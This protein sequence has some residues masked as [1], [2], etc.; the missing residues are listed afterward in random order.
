MSPS[1]ADREPS[2][3]VVGSAGVGD[4]SGLSR[5]DEHFGL[6]W[7]GGD[8]DSSN[9]QLKPGCQLGGVTIVRLLAEG[10]MGRV[11]EAR[12]ESPVRSVAV[13]VIRGGLA[14]AALARRFEYEAQVLAR[15]R[16]PNIAQI[17]TFGVHVDASG[18]VPFFVMEL[19]EDARTIIEH[20]RMHAVPMRDRVLLFRKICGA[21]AHGH[22]KGV[23]HRDLKPG[24]MLVDGD[25]EPKVI[26]FGVARS[27][28]AEPG[29]ATAMT[30]AGDVIGTL[31]Y[32]S[33][34]QFGVDEGDV[35]ARTDVYA[36]GLVL[37]ELI[38]GTL[39]YDVSGKSVVEVA[40]ILG[41]PAGVPLDA[42][43]S[44]A[45]A[46]RLGRIDA[47]TLA[48]ITGKCLEKRAADRY[49]TAVELEA[50]LDRWLAGEPI[51]ARPPTSWETLM[52]LARRHRVASLAAAGVLLSLVAAVAGISF[53]FL[54]S[55]RQRALADDARRIAE[56]RE[57][58]AERQAA[59]AR[60]QLYG[61]NVLLAAE[62]RDRDNVG[63]ARRLLD[64]ARGLVGDAGTSRPI[65]LDCVAAS[66]DESLR[67]LE[68][69][70]TTVTAV[71]WAGDGGRIAMGSADGSLRVQSLDESAP[72]A[73]ALVL[74]GHAGCVWTLDFSPDGAR[75]ASG[76]A[77][78]EV[79]I[80]NAADGTLARRFTGHDRGVYAASFSH[81][82]RSLVTG[83]RDGT[84]RIWDVATGQE[85]RRLEGH[86]GTVYAACFSP[87]DGA[88]ATGSL[89]ATARVW[90][91][92]RGEVRC[93]LRGHGGRVFD[94]E[95][96]PDGRTVATASEDGSARLWNAV[97][98]GQGLELRHP[99][100]VNALSFV[101][102]GGRLATASG[103][104]VL[105]VWSTSGGVEVARLRG[106]SA[107]VWSVDSVPGSGSV[108]TGSADGTART[109]DVDFAVSSRM[110]CGDKVLAVGCSPDGRLVATGLADSTIRLW[111]AATL[112]P[113]GL[114]DGAVGRVSAVRFLD[115][116]RRVAG[117]C[118]DGGVRIWALDDLE[119]EAPIEQHDRRIYSIDVSSDG[120]LMAT[121]ADDRTARL[122][123][124][125]ASRP[126][127][128]PLKHPRRPFC[129][130]FSP[131]GT[132]VATACEDR[133]ARLWRVADGVEQR[134]FRG[135]E[136]PV[137]WVAF[138]ADGSLLATA[139]SDGAVRLWHVADGMSAGVLTGPA[140]QVWKVA[141]SPDGRR[142]AAASA[143]GTARIWDV[144]TGRATPALRGHGD[145]VWG[146]AFAPDGK[147]LFTGSWDGT[148]RIWGVA[149]AEIARLRAAER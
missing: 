141:F 96:A 115:D 73:D 148:A 144:A 142:I 52:R 17:H 36:L 100:R 121:A 128:P 109:W 33:P 18:T 14:S 79:R 27:I 122:W 113:R 24:N 131:D 97:D 10:G 1:G 124:L 116:G 139:G 43:E 42:V 80:W 54:R 11:Y 55:E 32:M 65:E 3:P 61:S 101:G 132:L 64:A 34:E 91:V 39:P 134:Q 49:S 146:I 85:R 16:H 71:A 51:L 106:H 90:D 86:K 46:G 126:H 89:D 149:V 112:L 60:S 105:R 117:G 125:K 107:A 53:F 40:R 62:A 138:S 7:T 104:G 110:A 145:Q 8:A 50:D 75:I 119:Q 15:L 9:G 87:D 4:A 57:S 103:D 38:S 133:V 6:G 12:Q 83:G 136:G 58:E 68:G 31:R 29:E 44:A 130:A 28:D 48:T 147:S 45:R 5:C 111:D 98:G 23:I 63:E 76:A 22:R 59:L 127:G 56:L 88:V 93:T 95:F 118:D 19:V 70:G 137:N 143:D 37:H 78:G 20:V 140:H 47:R 84:A 69:N 67:V 26:D 25:G 13:K 108:A 66:L 82:G 41:D 123:D 120:R 35:D 102:D 77:D 74:P 135:H 21:V 72:A 99:F 30:R 129:A 92:A 81:D 2:E 94:V 114:L